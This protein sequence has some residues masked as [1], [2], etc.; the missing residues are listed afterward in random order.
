MMPAGPIVGSHTA[1]GWMDALAHAHTSQEW[2]G[3]SCSKLFLSSFLFKIGRDA[4]SLRVGTL[5]PDVSR[6]VLG[7]Q[8]VLNQYLD[9]QVDSMVQMV[10]PASKFMDSKYSEFRTKE[11]LVGRSPGKLPGGGGEVGEEP[12]GWQGG[13]AWLSLPTCH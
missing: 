3:H 8:W 11:F 1:D 6:I 12:E 9:E 10:P 5:F 7:T 4:S 13:T 2:K